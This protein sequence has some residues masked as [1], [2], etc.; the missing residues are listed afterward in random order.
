MLNIVCGL[1]F[2]FTITVPLNPNPPCLPH[3]METSSFSYFINLCTAKHENRQKATKRA[4]ERD[5]NNVSIAPKKYLNL[6][7]RNAP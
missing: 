3:A 7:A 5:R 1:L 6:Q 2:P 4:S